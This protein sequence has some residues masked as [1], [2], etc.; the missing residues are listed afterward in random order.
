MLVSFP[1]MNTMAMVTHRRIL[2]RTIPISILMPMAKKKI[3][4]KTS[5]IGSIR[6]RTMLLH[7][8][9]ETMIPARKA[10]MATDRPT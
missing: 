9:S 6:R 2:S 5:F 1:M 4:M 3:A 10:P 8:D 7:E